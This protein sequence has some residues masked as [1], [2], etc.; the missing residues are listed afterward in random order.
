MS[1]APKVSKTKKWLEAAA[2]V[3]GIIAL[4]VG[5]VYLLFFLEAHFRLQ[6]AK[7]AP[8]AYLAVF[9]ITLL[10]SSTIIIPAPGTAF[11]MAAASMW[12]P[13]IVAIAASIGGT[14]GEL[15]GYYA[16]YV[17]TKI[18]IT[19]Y[20]AGYERAV[21][22]MNR[23]GVWTISFFAFVPLLLF[24][25]VGIVAGALRVPVWKFLLACW[26]GRLPR[27]F[28]EAYFGAAIIPFIRPWFS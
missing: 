24:D 11:V 12:N 3:I 16:G 26:A 8:L 20:K 14:L 17:G 18:I 28:I 27:N 19:D 1:E 13:A 10:S 6:L 15:T 23:Y 5:I 2:W 9:V 22:W 4:T 25:L 21:G 7:Y